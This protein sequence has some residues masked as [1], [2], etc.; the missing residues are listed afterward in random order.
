MTK[1]LGVTL[2]KG[3]LQDAMARLDLDEDGTCNFQEFLPWWNNLKKSRH[4]TKFQVRV[5]AVEHVTIV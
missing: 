2:T 4:E 5:R 1:H 3:E